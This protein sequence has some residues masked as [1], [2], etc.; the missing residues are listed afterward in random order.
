[1]ITLFYN[2]LNK[3]IYIDD[4]QHTGTEKVNINFT[5]VKQKTSIQHVVRFS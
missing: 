5:L 4:E 3:K 2:L 1:M